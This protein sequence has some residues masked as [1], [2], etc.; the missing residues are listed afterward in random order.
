MQ[1]FIDKE[2]YVYCHT[3][4]EVRQFYNL[5][6]EYSLPF[7]TRWNAEFELNNG[8]GEATF[9]YD[10]DD[11]PENDGVSFWSWDEDGDGER[12]CVPFSAINPDLDS[13]EID[14][15]DFMSIL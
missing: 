15:E 12:E 10:W 11:A 13:S 5:C 8:L 6:K 7:T 14:P 1:R 4:E 9:V 2:Y 3:E